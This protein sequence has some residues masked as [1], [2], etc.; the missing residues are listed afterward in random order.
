MLTVGKHLI[1]DQPLKSVDIFTTNFITF[2]DS[3]NQFYF[4]NFCSFADIFFNH[5]SSLIIDWILNNEFCGFSGTG[6]SL[7]VDH[8]G[9]NRP[10][11]RILLAQSMSDL[12]HIII[13]DLGN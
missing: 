12:R 4:M 3:N 5:L 9:T 1:F 7:M 6:I 13:R 2:I 11:P 10:V 8:R